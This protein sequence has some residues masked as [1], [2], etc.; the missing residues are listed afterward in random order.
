MIRTLTISPHS[1]N[2]D[3]S[4]SLSTFHESEPTKT[5]LDASWSPCS[6]LVLATAPFS[7]FAFLVGAVASSLAFRLPLVAGVFSSSSSELSSSED[8][9]LD[10]AW[11]RGSASA[12]GNRISYNLPP[13]QRQ[14]GRP[15]SPRQKIPPRKIRRQTEGLGSVINSTPNTKNY[16][17]PSWQGRPLPE[18]PW[19]APRRIPR[20]K[21]TLRKKTRK[22][23]ISNLVTIKTQ[24]VARTSSALV[25]LKSPLGAVTL[26]GA[27]ATTLSSFSSSLSLSLESDSDSDDEDSAGGGGGV[28]SFLDFFDFLEGWKGD[29]RDEDGIGM[30]GQHECGTHLFDD[31]GGGRSGLGC[32]L[33]GDLLGVLL[34]N[35]GCGL[36]GDL[37]GGF[38]GHC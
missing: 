14:R 33:L 17:R 12:N 3:W 26:T 7:V 22:N 34:G 30:T 37:L 25:G 24:N 31:R 13:W 21:R 32:L 36:L 19:K 10:S 6:V 28:G 16:S 1:W 8:S 23:S 29:G 9:S 20:Q 2:S 27:A 38:F 5:F 18:Q 11:K 35:L 15:R 4:Q